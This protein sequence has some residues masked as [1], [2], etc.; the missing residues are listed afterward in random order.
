M[1]EL[2]IN[3]DTASNT[4]SILKQFVDGV[5]TGDDVIAWNRIVSRGQG[6]VE[7]SKYVAALHETFKNVHM[8][9]LPNAS[10]VGG[11]D[12]Q[13]IRDDDVTSESGVQR[14]FVQLTLGF[15]SEEFNEPTGEAY[16]RPVARFTFHASLWT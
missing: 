3:E 16:E 10:G 7:V 13:V 2:I 11:F 15:H 8:D 1:L 9:I 4:V 14:R 5:I 12:I 6:N